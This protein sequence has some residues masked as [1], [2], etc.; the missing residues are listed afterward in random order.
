MSDNNDNTKDDLVEK[1]TQ[2]K[3]NKKSKK[4][5]TKP[6]TFFKLVSIYYKKYLWLF[7]TMTLF[8]ALSAVCA[9][10]V[11]KLT[12]KLTNTV[13]STLDPNMNEVYKISSVIFSIFVARG[14]FTFFNLYIGGRLGKR[15]E[16]DLRN[17][18]LTNLTELDI[19]FYNDKKIGEI[20]TKLI[21]D[22]EVIGLQ[23]QTIPQS[24]MSALFISVGAITILFT[25]NVKLTILSIAL[26]LFMLLTLTL[27]FTFLRKSIFNARQ[28]MTE[29]NGDVTDRISN[30]NLIKSSG[31]EEYEKNRFYNLH[32]KYYK[33]SK[34]Q[35]NLQSL[36]IGFLIAFLSSINVLVLIVGIILWKNGTL[37][38][39]GSS[40]ID[41]D[42][43]GGIGIVISAM[44]GV[45]TLVL[46]I[47]SLSRIMTMLA[48]A[49]TS[50][51]RVTSLIK[52]K[53]IINP[54]I[55]AKKIKKISGDILFKNIDFK[56][57]GTDM[58]I[59]QK[60]N[61]KFEKGKTY[62]FVGETGVGKSTISK[63]LLRFYDPNKGEIFINDKETKLNELNLPSY[64][65]K[66]G[67]VEQEPSI[68]AGTVF[69]NIKYGSFDAT[70]EEVYLAAKNAEL[71]KFIKTL[72]NGYNTELGENGFILSGGQKQRMVIART[73]LKDPDVLI[74]DEATSALDN[75]VEKQ[76][77]R[78]LDKLMKG[79][80]T[81]II[82]HRLS[83]IKNADYI[84]V[85][86]KNKGIVQIGTFNE[87]T[88][89]PGHFQELYKAGLMDKK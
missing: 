38:G 46:P 45:N 86:E 9:I 33:V 16:I 61:F 22:T 2:K 15:I 53:S 73:F 3:Y 18:L 82:A 81:F 43:P 64:L 34:K 83:T 49:S 8:V 84:L 40:Q 35:I 32:K 76:I 36:L 5:K 28:T 80:T 30:I 7:L 87:L 78:N 29:I 31:T 69:E 12:Q 75:I 66:I 17:K 50:S 14:I 55:N 48:Q 79:R 77:Q 56:Y 24:I 54:N 21:S 70:N 11:P 51:M 25:I 41:S 39:W 67:Y 37:G 19:S 1:I 60:F 74:L 4:Q 6:I 71:D 68:L 57:P 85:L 59:F 44:T 10:A 63:L 52:E 42:D 27:L 72:K 65:Q 62:A 88:K 58:L 13:T 26:V 47:M 89:K 23:A 20:L